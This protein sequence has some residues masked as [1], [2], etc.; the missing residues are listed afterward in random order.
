[1]NDP[2]IDPKSRLI[3]ALNVP[4]RA[5]ALQCVDQLSGRVGYFKLGLEIFN[6]ENCGFKKLKRPRVSVNSRLYSKRQSPVV[7]YVP[8]GEIRKNRNI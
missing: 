1:M 8:C 7:L 2:M 5:A 6:S 4:D 3:I